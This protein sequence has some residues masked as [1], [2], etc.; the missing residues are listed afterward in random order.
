MSFIALPLRNKRKGKTGLESLE[1]GIIYNS[2]AVVVKISR[3]YF[4]TKIDG[5]R[6]RQD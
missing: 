4:N 1:E 6:G 5:H 3:K 2:I